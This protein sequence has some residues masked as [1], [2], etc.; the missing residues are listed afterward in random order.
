MIPSPFRSF[1]EPL[2][3]FIDQVRRE[4]PDRLV[5]ILVPEVVK[6]H[7][8]EFLLH[9]FRAEHL[10]SSILRRGD[11]R[12]V[13]VNVPWYLEDQDGEPI[14]SSSGTS[15]DEKGCQTEHTTPSLST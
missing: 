1:H 9:N 7:W 10:R 14:H 12:V 11:R 3:Q 8:W 6:Q 5:A 4:H 15:A 2:L 13:V